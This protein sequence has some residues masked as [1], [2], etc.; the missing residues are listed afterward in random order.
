M[1]LDPA[2]LTARHPKVET[3]ARMKLLMFSK[4]LQELSFERMAGTVKELGFD[5]FDLTTRTGGSVLPDNVAVDLPRVAEIAGEHGLEIGML[6]TE[7]TGSDSQHAEDIFGAAAELGIK[8]LKLGYFRYD[9]FGGLSRQLETIRERLE[10]LAAVARRYGVTACVHIHSGDF[11][12]PSGEILHMMIEEFDADEIGAYVDPGHMAV[13]GGV[14]A[15]MMGLDLL[16]PHIRMVAVKDFGWYQAEDLS[17]GKTAWE[18]K[19]VPL[20]EGIVRWP[21]VFDCLGQAGYDGYLS[22]HSEYQG[23]QSFKDMTTEEVIEQ[24]RLDLN[25]LRG[26]IGGRSGPA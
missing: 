8:Y 3:Y 13:E 18:T 16:T 21:D 17:L 12:P 26:V 22:V 6:T 24:T 5:G 10:G 9:G 19:L 15:W 20:S 14:G 11:I 1:A 23:A 25:Y 4:H 7:I 2:R